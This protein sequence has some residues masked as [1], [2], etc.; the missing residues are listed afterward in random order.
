[1]RR[2]GI[3]MALVLVAG[4]AAASDEPVLKDEKGKTSYAVGVE[5][6]HRLKRTPVELDAELVLRGVRDALTGDKTLLTDE[7]M[8]AVLTA[9]QVELRTR[10]EEATKQLGE[11]NKKEAEAFLAENKAKQGVVTLESGLQYRILKATEG[12]KPTADDTI[13]C[14]YRG[15]FIDGREFESSVGRKEPAAFAIKSM[16]KGWREALLL[17]P[18]GSKWQLFV[19]ADLAYGGRARGTIGPNSTL[20]YEVELLSIKQKTLAGD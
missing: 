5:T 6:G 11:K 16:I 13:V 7:E 4:I 2:N 19:P 10:R 18:V 14:H 15:T 9:L 8:R 12:A 3:V 17:M 20:I 1:M